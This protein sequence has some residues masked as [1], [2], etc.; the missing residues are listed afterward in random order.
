MAFASRTFGARGPSHE[1]AAGA[2]AFVREQGHT[3]AVVDVATGRATD[4]VTVDGVVEDLDWSPDGS[5]LVFG[6]ARPGG[7]VFVANADGSGVRKVADG[8]HPA[9]SP[10]GA[11]IAYRAEDGEIHIMTARGNDDVALTHVGDAAYPDWSADGQTIAFVGPGPKGHRDGTDIYTSNADGSLVANITSHPAID[12]EPA[13]SP[14]GGTILFRTDRAMTRAGGPTPERLYVMNAEGG[15]L[16]RITDGTTVSASPT[17]SPDAARVA[18]DDGRSVFVAA[19]DGSDVVRITEGRH[20]VWRPSV[21]DPAASDEPADGSGPH[22]LGLAF[23]V[24]DVTEVNGRFDGSADGAAYVASRLLGGRC[25]ALLNAPQVIAVDTD[26]DGAADATFDGPLCQDWCTA[27]A[28]PDIDGDG[29]AELLVQTAQFAIA[30][31]RLYDVVT[32]PPAIVPVV[33]QA[34]GE[35]PFE[36]GEPPQFWHGA[37]GYD[38]ESLVCAGAGSERVLV[39]TTTYQDPP[40]LGPWAVNET[41][42]R[43]R[44]AEL[45]VTR[46]RDFETPRRSIHP[47]GAVVC[48]A[49]IRA[50]ET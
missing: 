22:H 37:D 5:A 26:G 30:G 6:V 47:D 12:T 45:T 34:P 3:I 23:D 24:C 21:A 8:G 20:P 46:V 43:L 10:D 16:I 44:G 7:G 41:T 9:W 15:N 36:G 39:A 25:P 17:W 18:F 33:V 4:L 35:P 19:A 1:P 42:F 27:W 11:R 38:A 40:E 14:T 49:A 13:W 2:V 28:A 29:T 31:V 48:G 32:D 50:S